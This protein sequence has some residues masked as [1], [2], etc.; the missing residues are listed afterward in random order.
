[1]G[2]SSGSGSENFSEFAGTAGDEW[3][4]NADGS[5]GGPSGSS[6]SSGSGNE[7]I[8]GSTSGSGNSAANGTNSTVT[9]PGLT[10]EATEGVQEIVNAIENVLESLAP[11]PGSPQ[12]AP[13]TALPLP[14]IST[15]LGTVQVGAYA[16]SLPIREIS[17]KANAT[18]SVSFQPTLSPATGDQCMFVNDDGVAPST[19]L[20]AGTKITKSFI[21]KDGKSNIHCGFCVRPYPTQ[22]S[23]ACLVVNTEA[24]SPSLPT[25]PGNKQ[26]VRCQS[27]RYRRTTCNTGGFVD[28]VR[29]VNQLSRSACTPDKTW[30][31]IHNSIQVRRGCRADFEVLYK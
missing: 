9:A 2:K 15:N 29:L 3:D 7:V 6:N 25:A 8:N 10:P 13:A 17:M 30:K 12:V 16:P 18:Y 22:W 19:D 11:A 1:M 28:S 26:M 5:T 27:I 4:F 24:I 14:M 21:A 20:Y 31:V 23:Q